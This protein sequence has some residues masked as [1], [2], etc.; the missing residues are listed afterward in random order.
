MY[1]PVASPGAREA[2]TVNVSLFTS[3]PDVIEYPNSDGSLALA[4]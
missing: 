2:L 3:E 1:E 4:T